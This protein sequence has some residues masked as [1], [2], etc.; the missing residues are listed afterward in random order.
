[1]AEHSA[2]KAH[3]ADGIAELVV[4]HL[5]AGREATYDLLVHKIIVVLE[6]C[7]YRFPRAIGTLTDEQV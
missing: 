2:S 6:D 3:A 7:G 5:E 4:E 1:M